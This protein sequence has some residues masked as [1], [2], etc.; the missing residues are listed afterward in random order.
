MSQVKAGA[1]LIEAVPHL[2]EYDLHCLVFMDRK[3]VLPRGLP[4]QER[5]AIAAGSV[6]VKLGGS[7]ITKYS[8]ASPI[9]ASEDMETVLLLDKASI[10]DLKGLIG[11]FTEL[12]GK[13]QA[14]EAD[15]ALERLAA[16]AKADDT[17]GQNDDDEVH[18]DVSGEEVEAVLNE[19]AAALS[20]HAS[21]VKAPVATETIRERARIAVELGVE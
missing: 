9:P 11:T 4:D 20:P 14:Q 12:E 21:R 16:D 6:A 3:P 2:I 13:S 1:Y 17:D 5:T 18:V 19:V 15:S 10:A 7:E 8:G